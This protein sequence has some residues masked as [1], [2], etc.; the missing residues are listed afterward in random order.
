M[1]SIQLA[2]KSNFGILTFTSVTSEK[3][4][5]FSHEVFID[6]YGDNKETKRY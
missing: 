1:Y 5:C 6:T 2:L 4:C 3:T